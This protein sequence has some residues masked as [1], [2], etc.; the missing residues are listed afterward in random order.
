M[1]MAIGRLQAGQRAAAAHTLKIE[2]ADILAQSQILSEVT[3]QA[4]AEVAG[5]SVHNDGIDLIRR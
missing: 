3:A 4:W 1:K 5:T 2:G